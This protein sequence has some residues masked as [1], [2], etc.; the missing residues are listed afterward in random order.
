ME[1]KRIAPPA[2]ASV[3]EQKLPHHYAAIQFIV[4]VFGVGPR[5]DSFQYYVPESVTRS[6]VQD[7]WEQHSTA[8]PVPQT[9][10]LR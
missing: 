5:F 3:A 10:R 8:V 7:F 9:P 4:A 6:V 1:S 2:V